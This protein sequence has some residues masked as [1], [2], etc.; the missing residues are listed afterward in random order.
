MKILALSVLAL[1][2]TNEFRNALAQGTF[3]N[4]GFE[5][6]RNVPLFDPQ[7]HPWYMPAADALPGWACYVG[8]E[9]IHSVLYNNFTLD[10]AALGVASSTAAFVPNALP[11]GVYSLSLQ[12]GIAT[13]GVYSSASIAQ[14]GQI[15]SDAKSIRFRGYEQVT[16]G[17]GFSVTFGGNPIPLTTIMTGDDVKLYGG[18][19]SR[20]AGE[21]GELRITSI[22][23]FSYL[24][25]LVF[26]PVAVPEPPTSALLLG[27]L[28]LLF[29]WRSHPLKTVQM[30]GPDHSF[31]WQ[32]LRCQFVQNVHVRGVKNSKARPFQA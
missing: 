29:F 27:G 11:V 18:D 25:G 13:S 31:G 8:S 21:S 3:Q 14:V 22:S 12:A 23:H 17:I 30:A 28:T 20:F 26:S 5:A 6:V 1:S 16:G 32:Q 9:Q 15:P 19:I 4:L 24:D 10:A 2:C 7:A